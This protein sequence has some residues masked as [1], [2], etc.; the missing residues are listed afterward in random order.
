MGDDIG[1]WNSNGEY[2]TDMQELLKELDESLIYM[3]QQN[4]FRYLGYV[5]NW[6]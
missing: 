4:L 5:L 3:L 2:V 6:S 1:S